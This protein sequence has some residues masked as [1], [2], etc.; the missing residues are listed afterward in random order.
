MDNQ[1]KR[2]F[3]IVA[4]SLGVG[5]LPD[6]KDFKP[7]PGGDVGANT[8]A[9]IID[10][11]GGLIA[12]NLKKMG[13]ANTLIDAQHPEGHALFQPVPESIASYGRMAEVSAGKDTPSG[14]WE[15]AGC[16][17]SYQMPVYYDG[18]P[19]EMLDR[20]LARCAAAHIN[21]PGVLGGQPA[22]GTEI[23]AQLGEE[24]VRT[25]KPIVYTSGDSV[26]QIAAHE[27]AFGLERLYQ[28]CEVTRRMLNEYEDKIGRVIARPF[29]GDTAKNF[30]R[31]PN[32]HD[33]SLKPLRPTV[34]D[35]TQG[36]GLE[37]IS[38]GKIADI[39]ADQGI[40]RK[41]KSKSNSQSMEILTDLSLRRDWQGIAFANLT[42]F[43][44]LYGHRRNARG[45]R[46][47]I[48]D[49]DAEL[50]ALLKNIGD[51]DLV[52]I[53]ADHGCDPT[54]A[55]TD[56]T[57]EYVPVLL[58]QKNRPGRNLGTRKTFADC[59]ATI[60]AFLGLTYKLTAESLL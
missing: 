57:R 37:V 50:P 51:H 44:M 2:V 34:L 17:V 55:G 40:T 58:Y 49:F 14:H 6:A 8:L 33:Y 19:Q 56:H 24:H 43:D 59:A 22:S 21:L 35:A 36:A 16:P 52:I 28:V 4:D 39:F 11:T 29:I 53:T 20:F 47:A 30:Q 5:A 1:N 13:L 3:W 48:E 18:L 15:M 46:T 60:A 31:T 32:R 38:I 7:I 12:P 10:S 41:I 54:F 45:Y 27:E 25:G 9:H 23:I 42:D 26:F